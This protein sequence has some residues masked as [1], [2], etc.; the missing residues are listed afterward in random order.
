[1]IKTHLPCDNKIVEMYWKRDEQAIIYTEQKYGKYLLA[2]AFNILGQIQDCQECVNDVYLSAWN[3][4]PPT[5]PT[6]LKCFLTVL[7]RRNAINRYH[8]NTRK[9]EIPSRLT[10]SLEELDDAFCSSKSIE[11]NL[12]DK[13]LG[14]ALSKFVMQLP[15]RQKYIFMSRYYIAQPIH[16]IANEL[17]ISKSTVNKEISAIKQSLIH[18]LEKEGY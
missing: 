4:I 6:F 1:M 9:K 2:V 18:F 13:M 10:V 15:E 8:R 5:R 17:S 3:A 14:E 11:E 7:L 12:D 16:K